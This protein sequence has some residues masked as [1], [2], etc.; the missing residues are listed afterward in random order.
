MSLMTTVV[1]WCKSMI[2]KKKKNTK[3]YKYIYVYW[4]NYKT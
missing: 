2:N 4:I 1:E 3:I